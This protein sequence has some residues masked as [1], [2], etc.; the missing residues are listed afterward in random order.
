ML[1][2]EVS[3]ATKHEYRSLHRHPFKR[4]LYRIIR[5]KPRKLP[6]SLVAHQAAGPSKQRSPIDRAVLIQVF[7][8]PERRC[9]KPAS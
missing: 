5:Y 9:Y 2:C 7:L 1:L 6:K 4:G 8:N 3:F